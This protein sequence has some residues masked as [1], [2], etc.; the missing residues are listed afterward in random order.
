MTGTLE[1]LLVRVRRD[2]DLPTAKEEAIRQVVVLPLLKLLGWNTDDQKE[3]WPEFQVEGKEA[4]YCLMVDG[5]QQVIIESKRG[6]E[7]LGKAHHE[8]QLLNYSFRLGI[9]L[10]VL[11]NGTEW[12]FYVPLRQGT[13]QE[14]KFFAIDIVQ[15][16]P[17][18]ASGYFA[19][20]LSRE[21]VGNGSAVRNANRVL[22][23]AVRSR[24]TVEVL[25]AVWA[26]IWAQPDD[27]PKEFLDFV[28]KKVE[29]RCGYQATDDEIVSF[30]SQNRFDMNTL[31]V[32]VPT[33][34][35]ESRSERVSKRDRVME[36]LQDGKW[37]TSTDLRKSLNV[38]AINSVLRALEAEGLVELR[39]T[40]RGGTE[41]RLL[42]S[43]HRA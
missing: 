39:R 20:F 34:A 31:K 33:E 29:S 6:G 23:D 30:L 38:D 13:W 26:D 25:P 15:Q 9:P 32:P 28:R 16:D 12:W 3:V 18:S 5:R 37:H 14:R 10:A 17:S 36:I 35:K 2:N 19:Q 27:L 11:T 8:D 7:Q 1:E 42:T 21:A 40:S 4:D 43:D 41:A 22:E 24:K